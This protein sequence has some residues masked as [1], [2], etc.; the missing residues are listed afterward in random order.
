[1]KF[2]GV[3]LTDPG[4]NPKKSES[5]S[6]C[7]V[8][9]KRSA[10]NRAPVKAS[11]KKKSMLA[12]GVVE[13]NIFDGSN[14]KVEGANEV[15]KPVTEIDQSEIGSRVPQHLSLSKENHPE[16]DPSPSKVPEKS[17]VT[18]TAIAG[19]TNPN[20]INSRPTRTIRK[21]DDHFQK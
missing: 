3:G 18:G 12:L 10:K 11:L 6:I 20:I 5:L 21:S 7:E 1:M 4:P 13:S 14:R 9:T 16:I 15:L 2:S 17:S 19:L 8:W